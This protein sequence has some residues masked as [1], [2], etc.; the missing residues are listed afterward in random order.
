MS[1]LERFE[2]FGP[3]WNRHPVMV[4]AGQ[5]DTRVHTGEDYETRTLASIFTAEPTDKPKGGGAAFI[6]SSY[7][8]Y[9]GREHKA[10]RERGSFVTLT[11]DIDSGNHTLDR[12]ETLVRAFAGGGAWLIYSSAH[13]RPGDLRWRIILP[14]NEPV[15]F[16][17]WHDAQNALFNFL[18]AAGI[19]V[20]RA[21]D[22]A[23]QPVYLPNVPHHHVKSDTALRNQ[24]GD[25][26]FYQRRSTGSSSPG[27]EFEG[28][29]LGAGMAAI[30]RRRAE[31]D[32]ERARIRLDAEKRRTTRATHDDTGLIDGFN[33]ATPVRLLL[34]Q[35]GYQQSPR[36]SD[37]YRSPHQTGD[38][39]ATRVFDDHWVSLSSSDAGAGLGMTCAS[40]CYGDA[41]DLFVHFEHQGDHRS[42]FRQIGKERRDARPAPADRANWPPDA[43]VILDEDGDPL[44][45]AKS[46]TAL[47]LIWYAENQPFLSGNWLIKNVL[48][49]EAFCTI[50][51]HPGCGKSFLALDL[52]LHIA[53]G[54]KWQD[55]KVIRGLV[56]Y[57]AAEGQ[58]GQ[59]NRVEAWKRYYE[60]QD[61][62]F[63]MIP[64]AINLG[65]RSED[66]GKLYEVI[67]AA[68]FIAGTPLVA[69]VV[70]TL[71]RTFGGGDE[72]GTDMSEYV[73]NIGK[74]Q[75]TFRC[76]VIVVHHIPKNS[77]T[78]SER[79]HGSLR[80]AIETSLVIS[81]DAESG[82]RTMLCKKQKDAEDGWKML[83]KLN[84]IELGEDE[85]GD[86]VTSCVVVPVLPENAPQQ[87][88]AGPRL[89]ATQRQALNELAA[90]IEAKPVGIPSDFPPDM[91]GRMRG[92]RA[93]SRKE[94]QARWRAIA[95]GDKSAET[96]AA[97][98][99]RAVTDLQNA[100]LVGAWNDFVWLV[101]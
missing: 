76:T 20:D 11:G 85:D 94:W 54:M 35:Y 16:A 2:Q 92:G 49:A 31:D 86:P 69:L 62:A 39:Y 44:P 8:D 78:V 100:G 52:A 98:F 29:A 28:G 80:G 10:Q 73:A 79:G 18:E 22:R 17:A 82:I 83:F 30:A 19:I 68:C 58:R 67:E 55:R 6:P 63:A 50:I 75:E 88:Q 25:P 4:F 91:R 7:N 96:A 61:V 90:T 89:T 65:A 81:A 41:Y 74:V 34:E 21:L 3:A 71:N 59:Q 1:N 99:R 37:D 42:A 5:S 84:V 46:E 87:I 43:T 95:A 32:R 60:A 47:P 57:I 38:T 93:G 9:D 15:A 72:N 101:S 48:P 27:L 77:E 26:L 12:I 14:L 97:T 56:L 45:L 53:A 13:A 51:G 66:L 23:A 36:D 70:D 33:T 64:V 40:G 24:N